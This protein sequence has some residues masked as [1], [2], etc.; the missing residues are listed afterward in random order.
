MAKK[1]KIEITAKKNQPTK[2][3]Q[4]KPFRVNKAINS[5]ECEEK[6]MLVLKNRMCVNCMHCECLRDIWFCC[7]MVS[8]LLISV[9]WS[10]GRLVDRT[11][12]LGWSTDSDPIQRTW[13]LFRIHFDRSFAQHKYFLALDFICVCYVCR[14]FFFLLLSKWNSQYPESFSGCHFEHK[15]GFMY[16][17]KHVNDPNCG[18]VRKKLIEEKMSSDSN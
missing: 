8:L 2:T 18:D 6:Y 1:Q 9:G 3:S 5:N 16:K 17:K 10:V 4:K 12:W 11:V 7:G 14:H 15:T 13:F